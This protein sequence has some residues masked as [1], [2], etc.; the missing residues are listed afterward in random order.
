MN[1]HGT[2]F[3]TSE[4]RGSGHVHLIKSFWKNCKHGIF[5]RRVADPDPNPEDP[6]VFRPPGSGSIIHKDFLSLKN[7]VNVPSK[8][9]VISQKNLNFLLMC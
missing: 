7:D 3:W 5:L 8:S 1:L 9:S 4:H 6:Y 2:E